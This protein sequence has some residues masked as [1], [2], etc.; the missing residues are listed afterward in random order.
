MSPITTLF[1][2]A[3][4]TVLNNPHKR[5]APPKAHSTLPSVAP[6]EL[7]RVRRKDFDSYL[8]AVAPEWERYE[9][10]LRLGQEG[11]TLLDNDEGTPR[12]SMSGDEPLTQLP[13]S[14]QGRNMPPL[15]S[16]PPVFFQKEFSLGDPKTFSNVTEQDLTAAAFLL[17][18]DDTFADPLSLS[19]SLPL[20]EKFSH[21]ADTVEQHLVREIFIRSPSF[22]AALTNLR[23]LQSESERCLNRITKLRKELQDV[24]NNSAKR[25]LEMVRK[26]TKMANLGKVRDGVRVIGEVVE[27]T[28]VAKSLVNAGQWGEALGVIES[29]EKLWDL[30]PHPTPE[31]A[32]AD[33]PPRGSSLGHSNLQNGSLPPTSEGDEAR[34]THRN[35]SEAETSRPSS[36]HYTLPVSS[37]HAFGPLPSHLRQLTME[38]A[39]SLSSELVAILRNDLEIRINSD[40]RLNLDA[41]QNL[42]QSLKPLLLNLVRT[43]GLKEGMLSWREVVML[44]VRGV[45]KKVRPFSQY[46]LSDSLAYR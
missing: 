3:I 36:S 4:S 8:R 35:G 2:I 10:N 34:E 19:Y 11:L 46:Y 39:A 38:I 40:G 18:Q 24:D 42:K 7:P 25:G 32:S 20:L 5:Q 45:V 23:D 41:D 17:P 31:N 44:E 26:E 33:G 1:F 16:V 6:A 12:N 37:L 9:H 13:L 21:Y 14:I 22:F 28:G 43:K 27:M 30:S 29:I 15:D